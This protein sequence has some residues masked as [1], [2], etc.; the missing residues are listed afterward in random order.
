[1][2]RIRPPIL[3]KIPPPPFPKSERFTRLGRY[4]SI[5]KL[6]EISSGRIHSE[7]MER[8]RGGY[9]YRRAR[10]ATVVGVNYVNRNWKGFGEEKNVKIN[11]KH[12]TELM[13]TFKNRRH[14][15]PATAVPLN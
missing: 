15:T 11:E 5:F 1:M 4:P 14:A 10:F 6:G 2:G 9:I 12:R 13:D 3:A 8:E 7:F